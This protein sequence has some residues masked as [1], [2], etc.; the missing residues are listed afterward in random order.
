MAK[1]NLNNPDEET[2][3]LFRSR[4]DLFILC[5]I[6]NYGQSYGYDI[7]NYLQTKTKGHLKVKTP[8]TIYNALKRLETQGLITSHKGGEETN[9]AVRIYYTVTDEGNNYIDGQ[10]EIYKYIR[11]MLDNL[12][13]DNDYDLTLDVPEPVSSNNL[14]PLTKRIKNEDEI[15][16]PNNLDQPSSPLQSDNNTIEDQVKANV[17]TTNPIDD[18]LIEG[19]TH[20]N[21]S[22]TQ[23]EY[24]DNIDNSNQIHFMIEDEPIYKNFIKINYTK[25]KFYNNDNI[26]SGFSGAKMYKAIMFN[27]LKDFYYRKDDNKKEEINNAAIQPKSIQQTFDELQEHSDVPTKS[28]DNLNDKNVLT[29]NE[30]VIDSKDNNSTPTIEPEQKTNIDE[31]YIEGYTI[32]K[33]TKINKQVDNN[34]I[35]GKELYSIIL[36]SLIFTMLYS[37]IISFVFYFV[38]YF[39]VSLGGFI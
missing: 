31:L 30:S 23:E 36:K 34:Q 33:Y 22:I 29:T 25:T 17:D 28:P 9:G 16:N 24:I 10:T 1:D 18:D 3:K 7:I 14:K 5:A 4:Y 20:T 37:T 11:T 27:T 38:K 2:L 15:D 6:R 35:K 8:S 12:I 39:E 19:S 13:S 32:N 21:E 26:Y